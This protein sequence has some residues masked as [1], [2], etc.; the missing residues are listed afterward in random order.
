MEDGKLFDGTRCRLKSKTGRIESA[1]IG[2]Y[3]T[4]YNKQVVKAEREPHVF[5]DG[6]TDHHL[7]HSL[8]INENEDVN[9]LPCKNS[10]HN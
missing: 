2:D 3:L 6:R 7:E 1:F 10:K 5:F 4:H 8:Y 9:N